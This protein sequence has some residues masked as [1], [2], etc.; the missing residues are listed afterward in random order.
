[1]TK[2]LVG[3]TFLRR[4]FGVLAGVILNIELNAAKFND[5]AF[6]QLVVQVVLRGL[7]VPH[8]HEHLVVDIFIS[9]G[10][11][12]LIHRGFHLEGIV[13]HLKLAYRK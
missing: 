2:T 13:F 5:I 7:G 10:V 1:M 9:N 11:T 4:L 8:N 12:I 6:L 3:T